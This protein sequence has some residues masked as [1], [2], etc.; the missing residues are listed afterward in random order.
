METAKYIS[1]YS[2]Q[3]DASIM[4]NRINQASE[5]IVNQSLIFS[6]IFFETCHLH[7]SKINSFYL[8]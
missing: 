6:T 1:M 4:R 3:N 8:L 5:T 2:Q 7:T